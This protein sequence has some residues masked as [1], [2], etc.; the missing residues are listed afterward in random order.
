MAEVIVVEGLDKFIKKFGRLKS[1]NIWDTT[2]RLYL[3]TMKHEVRTGPHIVE[4]LD[5]WGR[6]YIRGRGLIGRDGKIVKGKGSQ[7]LKE[8]WYIEKRKDCMELGN[9][10]TYA[11]YVHGKSQA[12]LHAGSGWKKLSDV[13]EEWVPKLAVAIRDKIHRLLRG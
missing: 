9:P 7:N 6:T 5:A 4:H 10:V 3:D 12:R 13:A 2:V 11:P 1:R 8:K